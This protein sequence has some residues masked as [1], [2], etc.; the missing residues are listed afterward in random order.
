MHLCRSLAPSRVTQ[1]RAG[2]VS[3][4]TKGGQYDYDLI[5]IG[6]GVGGHGA[7][8]HAVEQVRAIRAAGGRQSSHDGTERLD[9]APTP[10]RLI[11]YALHGA[12]Q[13]IQPSATPYPSGTSY[14]GVL[15]LRLACREARQR[16]TQPYLSLLPCLTLRRE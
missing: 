10:P 6:C 12:Q 8:L 1:A 3:Q 5:I 11:L 14:Q 2:V 7:A 9:G 15:Q 13:A 16:A 4:A